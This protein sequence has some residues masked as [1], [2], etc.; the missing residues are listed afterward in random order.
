[1][2][3]AFGSLSECLAELNARK[4]KGVKGLECRSDGTSPSGT[5]GPVPMPAAGWY[6]H[7]VL[8]ILDTTAGIVVPHRFDAFVGAT[9]LDICRAAV[10]RARIQGTHIARQPNGDSTTLI[11]CEEHQPG[12]TRS[13]MQ[14]MRPTQVKTTAFW[15]T[16]YEDGTAGRVYAYLGPF[17]EGPGVPKGPGNFGGRDQCVAFAGRSPLGLSARW[18]GCLAIQSPY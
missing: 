10:E 1:M 11:G 7:F 3:G 16:W 14:Y 15:A 8:S 12:T 2:L 17:L 6:I 4:A 5:S 9:R 18:V 13:L